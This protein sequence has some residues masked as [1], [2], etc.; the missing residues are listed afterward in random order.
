MGH[1][2]LDTSVNCY[3]KVSL[4]RQKALI[5]ELHETPSAKDDDRA[6]TVGALKH[7]L[8]NLDLLDSL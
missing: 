4:D 5:L 3:G 8:K 7:L 2:K 6:L 1:E